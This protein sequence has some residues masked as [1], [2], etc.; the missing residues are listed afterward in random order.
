M[1]DPLSIVA[2]AAAVGGAAGKLV[3]KT[4]DAGE[5]WLKQRFGTHQLEAQQRARQNA[6]DFV[7][8]LASHLNALES[9]RLLGDRE[10]AS[11]ESHPQFARLLERT[12]LNAAETEDSEKHDLLARLVA[13]RLVVA[14]ETTVA[15][16]SQLASDTITRCTRD[17]LYLLALVCFV[18]EVNVRD[19]LDESEFQ[20]WLDVFLRPFDDFVFKDMDA[21]HLVALGAITYD[22]ARERDL[23]TWL[24]L[25]NPND[26]I[27]VGKLTEI[28]RV[29]M[30][31]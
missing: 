16:A 29:E 5:A 26:D 8:Q 24:Q 4:W 1:T 3:E 21:R 18:D 13:N 28:T 23:I 7:Q 19:P 11:E 15:L 9:Q 22:P 12:L 20:R 10:I 2:L 14:S 17:Q 25:K 30:L 31:K 6:A 27:D